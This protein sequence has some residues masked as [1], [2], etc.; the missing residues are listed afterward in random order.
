MDDNIDRTR[1]A[2]RLPR[3]PWRPPEEPSRGIGVPEAS[4]DELRRLLTAARLLVRY[5]DEP[6]MKLEVTWAFARQLEEIVNKNL[7]LKCGGR[8]RTGERHNRIVCD[9]CA[10]GGFR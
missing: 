2:P 8:G 7:C 6:D 9:V 10:G 5:A 1:G 3:P 4:V